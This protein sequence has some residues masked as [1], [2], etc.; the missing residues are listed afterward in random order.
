MNSFRNLRALGNQMSVDLPTDPR[1]FLGRE[2]PQKECVGYFKLKPGTGLPGA[3][4]PCNCPYCG[5]T[6]SVQTFSTPE[7]IEYA[8]SIAI[9]QFADAV[10]RDLKRLEFDIPARGAFG[11]GISMKLQAGPLPPIRSYREKQLET[12]VIC[13]HCTLEFSVYGAFGYCP[14]CRTHNSL[15]ILQ[16]NIALVGKQLALAESVEDADLMR[17]L[18]EDALENCISAFDGFGRESCVVRAPLS[19]KPERARSMSFQNLERANETV[20]ECFDVDFKASVDPSIWACAES[21]FFKR[22]VIS[23]RSGIVDEKYISQSGDRSIAEGRRIRVS[24]SEVRAAASAIESIGVKL[25]A[26]LPRP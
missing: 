6:G 19:R 4:L 3:G 2:C 14:D 17:H 25:L 11:I 15:Q 5:H 16:K 18:V 22:H 10:Q 21:A 24:A 7:Q 1:G 13:D 12:D 20:K 9:R 26:V 8:Q 23:H